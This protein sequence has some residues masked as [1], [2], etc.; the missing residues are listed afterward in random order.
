MLQSVFHREL[1]RMASRRIYWVACLVL[2]LFSLF[3][4]AT[5]F[6]DGQMKNLPVG[7]VD[8]DNTSASRDIV[9]MV[10]ATPT[11]Q[12]THH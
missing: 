8:A 12:I 2:P 3:F 6:G 4:M 7:V 1:H 10:D 9:R 5:I 11:L